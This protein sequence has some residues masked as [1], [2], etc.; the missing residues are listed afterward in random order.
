M[1][2]VALSASSEDSSLEVPAAAA[3]VEASE[4]FVGRWTRLVSTT[5]WE[6]GR[7]IAQWREALEQQSLPVSDYSDETWAGLVGGVTG[8]HVGRLRR[9]YQRFHGIH[10]QFKGLFWSHVQAA[11]DWTDAE[12]WLEGAMQNA[13]S[14]ATMRRS[15]WETLGALPEQAP[16]AEDIVATE[17]DED[18]EPARN[19][20]PSTITGSYE[21]VQGPD[22][23]QGPDFGEDGESAESSDDAERQDSTDYAMSIPQQVDPPVRPFENLPA[24]PDDVTEAFEQFKLAI[25]RHKNDG[26]AEISRD[27]LLASLESLKQLAMTPAMETAPF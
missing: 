13:W 3:T 6:K 5:N 26:W 23:S 20:T 12:M 4:P 10:E 9:V 15:R 1:D 16:K 11:L 19:E 27:D 22:L 21:E 14:V 2:D 24:L 25:L 8:Q 7:I 17:T 18:F